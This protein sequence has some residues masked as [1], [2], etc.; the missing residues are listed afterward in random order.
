MMKGKKQIVERQVWEDFWARKKD[1][2]AVYPTSDRILSQIKK[3]G[4]LKGKWILE[5]GAGTGRDSLKLVDLGARVIVLDYARNSLQIVQNL[6]GATGK[7]VLAIRADAFYL[8]FR[9]DVIDIVF[10]QGLLEHF[11]APLP[12]VEENYRVLKSGGHV[13]I[14]VPQRYHIYTMIKHILIYFNAWFAGW[15]TEFSIHELKHLVQKAGFRVVAA[16]GDW[17]RPSLFYR[18]M[19]ELLLKV[20]IHL[21]LFPKGIVWIERK[22]A[23]LRDSMHH[24]RLAFYTYL[25]IGVVGEKTDGSNGATT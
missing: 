1:V 11:K 9:S 13:L 14:D 18:I 3:I 4:D 23:I 15:E 17:M 7:K 2:D 21:P 12:M 25:D 6:I 8:P 10:H 24:T 20:R 19:R 5:V 16:Y 22:R